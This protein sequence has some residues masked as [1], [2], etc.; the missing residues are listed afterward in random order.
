M[1]DFWDGLGD[2]EFD[3]EPTVRDRRSGPGAK[4]ATWSNPCPKCRGTGRFGNFGQCYMCK[5]SGQLTFKSSPEAR[6]VRAVGRER[7]KARAIEEARAAF[8]REHPA[9]WAWIKAKAP[10]FDF[11]ASM[12][13]AID[14]WGSLTENQM[15]AVNRMVQRDADRLAER[16]VERERAAFVDVSQIVQVFANAR[17]HKK[18]PVLKCGALELAAAPA[19]G[20]NPGAIYVKRVSDGMYLGKIEGALFAPRRDATDGDLAELAAINADPL[21]AAQA[22]GKATG[23]CSCCGAEL[24]NPESIALGIGPICRSK[25]GM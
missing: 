22:H 24:T 5:G 3:S 7:A 8:M 4:T 9:E 14:K 25:W 1:S 18:K 19:H 23:V 6:R 11:A 2:E 20:K 12:A 21:A 16:G 15:A 10:T 13:V 17:E